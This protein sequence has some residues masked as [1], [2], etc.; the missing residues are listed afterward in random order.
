MVKTLQRDRTNPLDAIWLAYL[1][2]TSSYG[3]TS[4]GNIA[5]TTINNPYTYAG[6]NYAN[7]HA[8]TSINGVILSYDNNGN[9]TAY[10]TSTY[11][12]NYRNQLTRAGT[13]SATSSYG[14]DYQGNRVSMTSGGITTK[15]ANRLYSTNGATTTKHIFVGDTLIATV[16]RVGTA[17]TTHIIHTDHLGGTNVVTDANGDM[18]QTIDY[19]PYGSLRINSKSTAM[20]EVRKFIGEQYDADTALSY[21]NARYFEGTR[22]QFLSQDPTHLAIGDPA[23]VQNL[24]G[25]TQQAV[26]SEPQLLNSYSYARN[27]PI[28][29]KDPE[30]KFIPQAIVLG[31]IFGG[32]TSVVFQGITDYRSGQFS[33][34]GNYA[35]AFGKGAVTGIFATANPFLSAG[36]AGGSSLLGSYLQHGTV[37]TEDAVN[38]VA[39]GAVTGLTAGYLKGLPQVSG[40]QAFR[41]FG[42]NYFT[43]A[44]A[45]RYAQEA[46]F[47]FGIDIYS[48]SVQG[49][50][51]TLVNNNYGGQQAVVQPSRPTSSGGGSGG[52]NVAG[53]SLW[54]INGTLYDFG[55]HQTDTPVIIK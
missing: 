47:G 40:P 31:G 45:R 53:G 12:W 16:E 41:V 17:T 54:M 20:D 46:L 21:L 11:T 1:R 50:T 6:T 26:L 38:A 7:P 55:N 49:I 10:G 43:G 39:E 32:V 34:L 14:Y 28:R 9:L 44:H 5:S 37:T 25:L 36:V 23:K 35:I 8:P 22:G 2:A 18:V 33:G 30:G 52:I 51:N 48:S 29:Y 15:Y 24:T 27:N 4:I 13:G 19:Y 42:G 3:Y